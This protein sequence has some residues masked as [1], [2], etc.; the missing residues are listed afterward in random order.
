MRCPF[1]LR[2]NDRVVDTRAYGDGFTIRRRR[3]CCECS[4]RFTTYERLDQDALQVVKN[5]GNREPFSVEKIRTG[6]ARACTKR[7][8]SNEDIERVVAGIQSEV[9]EHFETEVPSRLIGEV[10]MK[11]LQSFD[12]V[13]YVRFASVYRQF[14]DA[15]DFVSELRSYLPQT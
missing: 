7:P 6:I 13:A 8:I 4:R 11:H 15:Q 3:E 1:C 12:Q 10:V 9:Y 14:K 5:N 2:D